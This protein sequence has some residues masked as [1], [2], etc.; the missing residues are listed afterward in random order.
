MSSSLNPSQTQVSAELSKKFTRQLAKNLT[1]FPNS[2]K[3]RDNFIKVHH[4][5]NNLLLSRSIK[6]S[7]QTITPKTPLISQDFRDFHFSANEHQINKINNERKEKRELLY[8]DKSFY[9]SNSAS[10]QVYQ[11]GSLSIEKA[12]RKNQESQANKENLLYEIKSLNEKFS[13]ILSNEQKSLILK[14]QSPSIRENSQMKENETPI[15]HPI[16]KRPKLLDKTNINTLDQ[17]I[18]EFKSF[19]GLDFEFQRKTL[20][21][22]FLQKKLELSSLDREITD[23]TSILDGI[24]Q[25]LESLSLSLREKKAEMQRL[26]LECELISQQKDMFQKQRDVF[27]EQESREK[28]EIEIQRKR[29]MDWESEIRQKDALLQ[30]K[31]AEH[32]IVLKSIENELQQLDMRKMEIAENLQRCCDYETEFKQRAEKQEEKERVLLEKSQNLKLDEKELEERKE[33]LEIRIH[34]MNK[35]EEIF[36]QKMKEIENLNQLLQRSAKENEEKES[37]LVKKEKELCKVIEEIKIF[38][39]NLKTEKQAQ[40]KRLKLWEDG[41]KKKKM[42]Y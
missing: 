5:P 31:E 35:D 23:K 12:N 17:E 7:Q 10:K 11:I 16:S 13:Q 34:K 37:I 29:L 1:K 14:E 38:S 4:S 2:S 41:L 9:S 30:S 15:Q 25:E 33:E 20:E 8:T 6:P 32:N 39:V 19:D 27:K 42:I 28:N 40:E 22:R 3:L 24:K 36:N 21:K 18:K 26:S